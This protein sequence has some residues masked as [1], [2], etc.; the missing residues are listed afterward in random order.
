MARYKNQRPNPRNGHP[1]FF[2]E[3]KLCKTE[4]LL[5]IDVKV[6]KTIKQNHLKTLS[7]DAIVN[8]V[9]YY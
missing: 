2:H 6:Y 1:D 7:L 4:I 5:Y 9:F 3:N 8:S